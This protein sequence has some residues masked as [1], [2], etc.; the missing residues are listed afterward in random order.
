MG[1]RSVS[2][3]AIQCKRVCISCHSR[4]HNR[5]FDSAF[6]TEACS[7]ASYLHG[8]KAEFL[9]TGSVLSSQEKSAS[10]VVPVE[11]VE[12]IEMEEEK[13]E[14]RGH[15]QQ[16]GKGNEKSGNKGIEQPHEGE[17]ELEKNKASEQRESGGK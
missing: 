6:R 17:G 9:K 3:F 7:K 1:L 2:I 13:E 16:D 11:V 4:D 14:E 15:Q 10:D 8:A 5:P 12:V